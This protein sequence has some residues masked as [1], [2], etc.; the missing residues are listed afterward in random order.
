MLTFPALL[1]ARLAAGATTLCRCWRLTRADGAVFGFTNHDRS[2]A[3]DGTLCEA[4]SG[5]EASR[6][7]TRLG[8]SA[9]GGEVAGALTSARLS[10][11]DILR[12]LYDDAQV[13]TFLVDWTEPT[14]FALLDRASLGEIRRSDAAF[15]AELRGP[16]HAWDQ[17]QGR[18]FQPTCA[19]ELGDAHC[20]VA[21][22]NPAYRVAT[23][24]ATTDGTL[25]LTAAAIASYVNGW[26][27][28]GILRVLSGANAGSS[29]PVRDHVGDRLALWRPA[30]VPLSAGDQVE[31]TAGCDRRY[32]TCSEKFANTLNFRGFPHIPTPDYVLRYATSG[33]GGHDGR[34]LVD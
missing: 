4:A 20:T 32:E 5:L 22:A 7:E 27:T 29:F 13:E 34:A 12:G 11:T 31:A 1:S 24:I 30:P 15:T 21:L 23:V 19:A 8:F 6:T 28:G 33:E 26:F 9:G 14:L 18:L 25:A 10:D 16:A 17:E 2:L 3:V